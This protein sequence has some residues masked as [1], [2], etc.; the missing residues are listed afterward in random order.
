MRWVQ[1]ASGH[2]TLAIGDGGNDVSMLLQSDCGVGIRG[3]EGEQVGP[4]GRCDVGGARGRLRA[5]GVS[6]AAS[7]AVRARDAGSES[8]LDDHGVF[9]VQIGGAVRVPDDVLAVHAVLGRL[10]VLLAAP[11]LLLDPPL[12]G[13]SASDSSKIPIVGLII[14]RVHS[15]DEL[16]RRPQL[17]AYSNGAAPV[18]SRAYSVG[19]FIAIL[20]MALVQGVIVESVFVF[21]AGVEESDF[22][23][24]ATFFAVYLLQDVMMILLLPN[25]SFVHLAV[26]LLLHAVFFFFTHLLALSPSSGLV[27]YL[28]TQS[29]R[30]ER[31]TS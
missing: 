22:L 27:P 24:H 7:T 3:R 21:G 14:K 12:R 19:S 31:V 20:G 26:V 8:E 2:V 1:K 11:D 17:Y 6:V 10:A 4:A 25:F 30:A 9:A 15:D 5:A 18:H 23:T 29:L 13:L 28:S 16:L